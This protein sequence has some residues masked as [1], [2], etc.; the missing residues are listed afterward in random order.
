MTRIL[1]TVLP[2]LLAAML[3][4]ALIVQPAAG[5]TPPNRLDPPG[6]GP[7]GLL[8]DACNS[9]LGPFKDVAD[10]FDLDVCPSV[11]GRVIQQPHIWNVFASDDWDAQNPASLSSAAINDITRGIIDTS[12][13]NDYLGPAGQYGVGAAT[14]SGSS[15]NDGCGGAPS[16]TTNFVSILLWITC[17]VQAPLTGIPYPD[18]NTLY[19]IYLPA[20]VDVNNGPF[21]GTCDGFSAYHFWS[22]ALTV[23]FTFL[24]P[25]FDASF[26]SYPF[27][28][29]PL[30]CAMDDPPIGSGRGAGALQRDW[31]SE[32][33]SH[34][35][36]EAATD[37]IVPNGWLDR[38][39]IDFSDSVF[40]EGEAADICEA[41]KAVPSKYRR[42]DNGILVSPYWSNQDNAC[43]PRL[44]TLSLKTVGLPNGGSADVTSRA[45][46]GDTNAH[47]VTLPHAF[48]TDGSIPPFNADCITENARVSWSFP[49]PVMDGAG[50]R[51]VTGNTGD[52]TFM[53][54]DITSTAI[55]GKQYLLTTATSPDV[56]KSLATTFTP[57][58]WVA[59]GSTIG[60]TTDDFVPSG[61]DRYRFRGWSWTGDG[62]SIFSSASIL[63]DAPKTATADYVLQHQITFDETGIPGGVPWNVTVRG[64]EQ[65]GPYS[66]WFDESTSVGFTFQDPVPG[67][68]PG[69]QYKLV[70]VDA[71]SPLSVTA[72]R[73]VTATYKKQYLLTVRTS[74]LPS[75]NVT[76]ITNGGT[77]LGTANDSTP[78]QA[79]IDD[80]TA[81]A[82]VGDADVN[83]IDGT[84]YFAQDFSPAPPATMTGPFETTLAYKTMAQ[85]IQEALAGGGIVGPNGPGVGTALTQQFAAVQADMGAKRYVP[86]LNDLSAFVDLVTAQCCAPKTG[87]SITTPTAK[88]LRLNAMLVYRAA[89]CLAANKL[90]PDQLADRYRY[91]QELVTSLGGTVLPPCS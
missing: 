60:V 21:G 79:W 90:K 10:F 54:Q 75:P 33:A 63:M 11:G 88:T 16:G 89:L 13:G 84:Q 83:G 31:V 57:T 47:P 61:V 3:L 29:I 78:L 23:D 77:A 41:G 91:Y 34:E 8:T 43:V 49:S 24:P 9:I 80:G 19:V 53:D 81:L 46:Y 20:N 76:N 30:K 86:A 65:S 68:T 55:Y 7:V 2:A 56:V 5:G 22:E 4:G 40:K 74:G 27:A 59:S 32:M 71:G 52:S 48:C 73:T 67:L 42:L 6:G 70:S 64:V 39:K 25:S 62:S 1:R 37:P 36:V 51:Y 15:Q 26:Q 17:E 69:T 18:D 38:S 14:F 72:T 50:T 82:L 35:I 12:A 58:Q 87:M 45:I 85:L 66:Q 28:V 44:H